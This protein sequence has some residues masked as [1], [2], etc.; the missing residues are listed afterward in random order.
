MSRDRIHERLGGKNIRTLVVL[1]TSVLIIIGL[2]VTWNFWTSFPDERTTVITSIHPIEVSSWD[3]KR[4]TLTVFTIS[5][6]VFIDGVFGVGSLPVSSLFRLE[7]MDKTKKGLLTLSLEDAM[8]TPIYFGDLPPLL[9]LRFALLSHTVR[10]DGV[11][12]IDLGSLGAYRSATLP[13]GTSVNAFDTNRFDAVIGASLEIDSIRREG[14]R[15]RVV[16]TTDVAGLG[17]RAARILSHAGMVVIMVESD[18]SPI[19]E[20][21]ITVRKPLWS[22]TSVSFIKSFFN[23][24]VE[25]GSEDEQADI[26]IRLGQDYA[27]RFLPK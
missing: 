1:I 27:G 11:T 10:P 16:N 22:S 23:C 6:D 25:S 3:T 7:A 15:V 24:R 20:C 18:L 2:W 12:R 26:T 14:F 5:P 4:Q 13:D 8:G 9:R 19:K 21:L 17:N